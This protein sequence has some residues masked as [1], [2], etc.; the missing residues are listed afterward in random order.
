MRTPGPSGK[1]RHNL[2]ALD[3]LVKQ[4]E[5]KKPSNPHIASY[6]IR[7]AR[8]YIYETATILKANEHRLGKYI[9]ERCL[10][11]L[12]RCEQKLQFHTILN[13]R[14]EFSLEKV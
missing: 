12:T 4:L 6:H 8:I 10:K 5:G 14:K 11:K 13:A 7:L 9:Q 2:K 1:I 3:Q